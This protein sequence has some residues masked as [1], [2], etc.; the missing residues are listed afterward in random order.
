MNRV[1]LVGRL[2]ATPEL[3]T[4]T[5]GVPVT[6]FSLAVNRP[7]AKEGETQADFIN[8]LAWRK[9]AEN[10]CKYLTKG[11][12]ISVDGRIQTGSYDTQDGTK[13]YTFEVVAENVQFLES[14][15]K[16]QSQTQ[17]TGTVS[18]YDFQKPE[19]PEETKDVFADFGEQLSLPDNFLD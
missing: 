15:N 9:Q 17:S 5:S 19:E 16:T 18:P 3:K 12:Q 8:I 14:K 13:R 7:Y 2:T 10:I 4:T 11:S 1:C 6:R